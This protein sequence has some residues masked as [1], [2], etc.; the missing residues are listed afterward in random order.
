LTKNFFAVFEYRVP[1]LF[2]ALIATSALCIGP[3]VAFAVPGARLAGLIAWGAATGMYS[4]SSRVS[5]LPLWC[6]AF[7]PVGAAVVAYAMVRSALVTLIRGGVTWRGTFY[8]LEELRSHH[9]VRKI[10]WTRLSPDSK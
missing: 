3:L 9:A 6:A 8:S 5:R 2:L 1:L 7:L 4:I 10:G